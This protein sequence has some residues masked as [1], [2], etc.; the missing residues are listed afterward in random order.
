MEYPRLPPTSVRLDAGEFDHLGPLFGFVGDQLSELSRRS[1]QRHAAEVSET[2]LYLRIVESRVDLLVELLDDLGGRVLGRADALPR[3]RLVAWDE[4]TQGRDFRE[5]LRASA[6]GYRERAELASPDVL[7][8][9]RRGVE[10][11]LHLPCEQISEQ[12]RPAA[13]G[14]MH[15]VDAGHHLEQLAEHMAGSADAG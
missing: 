14:Q 7:D 2:G 6:R 3:A 5:R 15:H 1:R 9:R 11:D 4:L 12:G 8:R 10:A 13:I